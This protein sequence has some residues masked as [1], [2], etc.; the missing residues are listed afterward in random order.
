MKKNHLKQILS[1]SLS[2]AL[3][4]SSA[5]IPVGAIG[6]A[7]AAAP[8]FVAKLTP[9]ERFGYVASS[10][11]PKG[12]EKP[13]LIIM[14]DLH[15]HV[16]VQHN[17]LNMLE[18]LVPKLRG[19]SDK[20]VPIFL[21]G[22][23]EANLEEPLKG[24]TNPQVRSFFDEYYLQKAEMGGPQAYSEHIAGTNQVT[25]VGVE[26][27]EEYLANKA[28]FA[29]TYPER[30]QLLE[31]IKLQET[32]MR[33]LSDE[34]EGHSFIKLQQV[35]DDYNAGRLSAER[36]VKVLLRYVDRFHMEGRY[37]SALRNFSTTNQV[38]LDAALANVYREISVRLS[39]KRPMTAFLRQQLGNEANI[40]ENLARV[41]A[42][43]DL[44]KRLV[45]DQLTPSEVTLAMARIS[46]LT[47]VAEMLLKD[48][49]HSI[50]IESV[51]RHSLDFYP[52]A[53]LRD[54]TLVKNSLAHLDRMG[55]DA[56][57]ILVAGGFHTEAIASYLAAHKISNMVIS[58]VIT[59]DLT[60]EEQLNYVKRMSGDH[61]APA[62]I[63]A[64]LSWIKTGRQNTIDALSA[65][66]PMTA[67]NQG[68]IQ[69]NDPKGPIT[70]DKMLGGMRP[71]VLSDLANPV[72]VQK[73]ADIG[74]NVRDD[75]A[76]VFAPEGAVDEKEVEARVAAVQQAFAAGNITGVLLNSG[77]P[78]TTLKLVKDP[79]TNRSHYVE[80]GRL[81]DAPMTRIEQD[82]NAQLAAMP[83]GSTPKQ[84][85]YVQALPTR[86][87]LLALG[88]VSQFID[89]N[90]KEGVVPVVLDRYLQAIA[91]PAAAGS[92]EESHQLLASHAIVHEV[93]ESILR[94]V[95][96]N[97][98]TEEQ[99]TTA[100]SYAV[101][102]VLSEARLGEGGAQ[103]FAAA[104]SKEFAL[105]NVPVQGVSAKALAEGVAQIVSPKNLKV[106]TVVKL[107]NAFAEQHLVEADQATVLEAL[108]NLQGTMAYDMAIAGYS[109]PLLARLRKQ[110]A[111]DA[112][113][114]GAA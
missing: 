97:A 111:A 5:P 43:L 33:L 107:A 27:K 109:A 73:L 25:M 66:T 80:V 92:V 53:F 23:W 95:S 60:T 49:P 38:E 54:E 42:D 10:Y 31:A 4:V 35:R 87:G 90:E 32:S 26:D 113:V 41:D 81:A 36:Y 15:A 11:A 89:L 101:A 63:A 22:G 112:A 67:T 40:R 85:L 74:L 13:R 65:G 61:V 64:D 108:R 104:A 78:G 29:K 98:T 8:A 57:G 70:G 91:E 52:L 16:E 2:L 100:H 71:E 99:V 24:M 19:Q 45:S 37:V 69:T 102:A 82:A 6:P 30:R 86:A 79:Q 106:E 59:R 7:E 84:T 68:Q 55:P 72:I 50:D 58:P 105:S 103:R 75:A 77:L 3:A 93:G 56:T 51:L 96:K 76:P 21:E 17:I 34:V 12:E 1:A 62:E 83:S 88:G 47:R 20:K 18:S 48:Q 28:R 39:E 94:G 9:P 46:S 114:A 44:L 14:S 110:L